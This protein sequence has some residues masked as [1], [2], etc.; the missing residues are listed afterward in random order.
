MKELFPA[1]T[2]LP[3]RYKRVGY[4]TLIAGLPVMAGLSFML[5]KSGL[6]TDSR[7]FFAEWTYPMVY[8]PLIIGLALLNFSEEREEDEMVLALRYQSFVT[9]VFYLVMGL[10]W[11]P[12]FSNI[13]GLLSGHALR[14]PD[15]G[16]M[17]GALAL[18][19]GYTYASFRY[20]LYRTRR[21]LETDEE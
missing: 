4:G 11:L 21:A 6:V 16:G 15:V 1:T 13:A 17:L 5:I 18:L 20:R 10:L 9:G 2:L 14:M 3:H 8:Y 19:L 7:A 12:F